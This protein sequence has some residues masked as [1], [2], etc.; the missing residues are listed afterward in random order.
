VQGGRSRNDHHQREGDG[1]AWGEIGGLGGGEV[2]LGSP[3]VD[4]HFEASSGSMRVEF[5][6]E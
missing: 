4:M 6:N 1:K 5:I 2:R 3:Y